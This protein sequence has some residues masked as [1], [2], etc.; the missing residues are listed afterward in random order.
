MTKEQKEELKLINKAVQNTIKQVVKK[1]SC[2]IVSNCI[3]EKINDYFVHA[4][5]FIRFT[6]NQCL[7]TIRMNI[8]LYSYNFV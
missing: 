6:N 4:V 3:Y 7:L 5:Y 8:K 2:K 1:K